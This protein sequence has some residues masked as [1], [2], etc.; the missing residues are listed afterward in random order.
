MNKNYIKSGLLLSSL[1]LLLA[2]IS[3]KKQLVLSPYNQVPATQAF[4]TKS[5]FDNA[6]RGVYRMMLAPRGTENYT[7]YYGG[8]D[9]FTAGNSII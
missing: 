5:D 4:T 7:S 3:C 2:A 1:L 6:I 9:Y 8:A